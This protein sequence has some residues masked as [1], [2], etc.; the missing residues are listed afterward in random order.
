MWD[1]FWAVWDFLF[2]FLRYFTEI[3]WILDADVTSWYFL[4]LF[5]V[6]PGFFRLYRLLR[7]TP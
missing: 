2:D 6:G 5:A 4:L 1:L 7:H 3:R